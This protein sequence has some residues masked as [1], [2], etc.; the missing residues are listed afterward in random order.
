M[1]IKGFLADRIDQDQTVQSVLSDLGSSLS[2]KEM[3]YPIYLIPF[4][5]RQN[6]RNFLNE[7]ICRLQFKC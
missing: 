5:K 6:F 4:T 3:F 2:D 1:G 7:S